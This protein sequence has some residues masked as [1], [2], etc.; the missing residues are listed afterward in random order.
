MELEIPKNRVEP[1]V[2]LPINGIQPFGHVAR[3]VLGDVHG[4]CACIE[5]ASRDLEPLC[6]LVGGREEVVG[7]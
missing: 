2:S 5:L 6:K 4:E 3:A 7:E 1:R